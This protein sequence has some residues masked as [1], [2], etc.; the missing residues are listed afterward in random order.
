MLTESCDAPGQTCDDN[1]KQF[2]GIF[3]RYLG[4]LATATGDVTYRTS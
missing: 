3:A 1:Q 2:K 4:E